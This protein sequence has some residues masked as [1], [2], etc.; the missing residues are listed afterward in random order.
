MALIKQALISVS[1]KSGIVEFALQLK[2]FGVTI[3][4]TGGTASL[5][6]KNGIDVIEVADYT[7]YPEML[8]G[9]VKTLNPKIHGGLLGL[10]NN[11][12]HMAKMKE[13][14]IDLI[15]MAV[16]NLYPFE[17]TVAKEDVTLEDAM[18]NIDIGGPTML[19]SAAKNFRDV[20]VV[21]DS[22][23]YES[24]IDEMKSANGAV[25]YETNFSLAK[26]VF[27]HTSKY[28]GAITSYLTSLSDNSGEGTRAE[29][30]GVITLQY[31]KVRDMRYGE[32]PHQT[33]AFYVENGSEEP[34]VSNSRKLQGKELSFNNV[35]DLNA[36]IEL[37][38][39]F[40]ETTAVIIKHT[41]PCGVATD[42]DSLVDAYKKARD[43]DPLSAFGGV[44]GF[45]RS[46]CAQTAEE[47]VSTFV[48]AVIAP[49]FDDDAVEIFKEKKNVRLI[50]IPLLSGYEQTGYDLKR[51]VGGLL[52]QGRDTKKIDINSLKVVSKRRPSVD[53][54]KAMDF[55]WKIC[56]HVKSNAI[57][58][59]EKDRTV[60]IGAG[61]MSRV[62]SSKIAILKARSP[63]KGTVMASDAFFPFRDGI[64]A[65]AAA[66]ATAVIQPGGSIR[67][68]EIIAAANEHNMA[69]IFTGV[70]HFK[71]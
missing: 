9:R 20:T 29:Y 62:D 40:S 60:G 43:C 67:D 54:I 51:V 37:A 68:G 46:V 52:V 42:N 11:E 50:E 4:S 58:Y 5:L 12:A 36:A 24:V 70:R 66:G 59:A 16:V 63:V 47:I 57:V 21:V 38:K 45:N 14:D 53:E 3:I 18:E 44:I 25:S 7:G 27:Q 34:S 56:K 13:H 26:K 23:D 61:Q 30:P 19:R 1:D 69:M 65:A 33:S 41:N 28:D 35:I 22:A 10:R 15:D 2:E 48:E 49:G 17:E 8:D 39:E 32:N 55:A 71:H 31:K 64:D 6:R